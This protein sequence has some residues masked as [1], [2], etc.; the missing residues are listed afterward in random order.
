M[1]ISIVISFPFENL[2]CM[3]VVSQINFD[4]IYKDRIV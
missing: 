3:K 1:Q 2:K 4:S